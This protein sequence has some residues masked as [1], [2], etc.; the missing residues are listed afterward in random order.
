MSTVPDL[1]FVAAF[2]LSLY[3]V[4]GGAIE[5]FVTYPTWPHVGAAEFKGFHRV[6][7][8]RV[9]GWLVVP[10]VAAT[11]ATAALI[12][13]GPER[14]PRW[15]PAAALTLQAIT[16]IATLAV[17]VPIQRRLSRD[18][19]SKPLLERMMRVDRLFR[20]LPNLALALLFVG[21]AL[22]LFSSADAPS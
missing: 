10:F 12:P 11:L 6:V 14:L 19:Y 13:F 5:G 1:L 20:Q 15:M 4:G 2:A 22:V 9:I 21:M 3:C 17:E 7:D 8:P 16:W 18:G